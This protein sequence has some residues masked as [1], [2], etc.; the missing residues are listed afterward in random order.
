MPGINRRI[1]SL[2]K[3]AWLCVALV[4]AIT[5]LSAFIRLSRAGLGCEPWPQC[6]G[7]SARE[8]PQ[9]T[10][11]PVAEPVAVARLA[12]R[13]VAVATLILIIMMV[14]TTLSS[15]PMLWHEGRMVLGLLAL[16]L[17]LAILGR[18]T[19]DSRLPAVV[20]ANL[21]AGF[22]MFA[23]SCRLARSLSA[24]SAPFPV[25]QG[26]VRLAAAVLVAQIVLGGLVSAGHAG[27][28]CP[29]LTR[30]DLSVGTWQSLNPWH[31]PVFDSADPTNPAGALVHIL[32]RAGA[33]LVLAVL[34]PLGLVAWRRGHRGGAVLILLLGTQVALGVMLV[35]GAL[36][37]PLA[38]AHNVVAALLLAVL[39][40]WIGT[41]IPPPALRERT[42]MRATIDPDQQ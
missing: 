8:A 19:A 16:A 17:F 5:T 23:L 39:A 32:H 12:H 7:Q 30:C 21:L 24:R 34:L 20:L 25:P 36:P 40:G 11:Q 41:A 31:A 14:M 22:A 15:E 9:G 13:V 27:L 6:Y 35:L 1:R 4:L 33:L 29:E 38:L 10:A 28:S 37:L 42:R 18:W 2:K 3:M 26:W